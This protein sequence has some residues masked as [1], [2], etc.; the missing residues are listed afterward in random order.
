MALQST[1]DAKRDSRWNKLVSSKIKKRNVQV[2]PENTDDYVIQ[3][4]P[5]PVIIETPINSVDTSD[6]TDFEELKRQRNEKM[7]N[8]LI[9]CIRA[10]RN[11]KLDDDSKFVDEIMKNN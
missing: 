1:T 4:M 11:K 2:R 3:E 7:K 8:K 6:S 10:V 9:A 5:L